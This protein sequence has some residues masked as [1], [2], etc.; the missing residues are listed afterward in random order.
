MMNTTQ[1][2]E[3]T[4]SGEIRGG[5]TN[6]TSPNNYMD[7]IA[8]ASQ[9]VTVVA[10]SGFNFGGVPFGSS[11]PDITPINELPSFNGGYEITDAPADATLSANISGDTDHFFVRDIYV[12]EWTWR[13]VDPGDLPPGFHGPRPKERVL[14]VVGFSDGTAPVAVKQHQYVL[15]RVF[16]EAGFV[17]GTFNA[18]IT[19]QGDTWETITVPLSL[20]IA[21]VNVNPSSILNIPQGG[22]AALPF[23]IQ[24]IAGPAVDGHF[25]MSP[26]QLD[27]GLT[28]A[29][30]NFILQP[31]ETQTVLLE[32][33]ADRNAPLGSEQVALDQYAFRRKGFF[34]TANILHAPIIVNPLIPNKIFVQ[35]R[36]TSVS[37]PIAIQNN[38]AATD[39]GFQPSFL[40]GDVTFQATSFYVEADMSVNLN[41]FIG[42][43]V[44]DEFNFSIEW[45]AWDQTGTMNFSV[46]ITEPETISLH[47][48]VVTDDGIPISG[49]VEM[50]LQSNGNYTFHGSMRATGG[51]S[52][53]YGLQVFVKAADGIIL[54]AFHSGNIY[55]TDTPGDRDDPWEENLNSALVKSEW[56]SIRNN[57]VIQ[58]QFNADIGGVIGTVWD[59]VKDGLEVVVGFMVGGVVGAGIVLGSEL[60]SAAGIPAPP[61]LVAGVAV[62]GG[63]VVLFGPGVIIPATVAGA[64]V[65]TAIELLI[66]TRPIRD[67]EKDFARLVFGNTL[68]EMFN[69]NKVWITNLSHDNG[70]KFTIPNLDG[71]VLLNL[72]DAYDDPIHYPNDDPKHVAG[73]GSDYTQPGAVFA[74]EL[75]HA[76]QIA[77]NKFVPGMICNAPGTYDYHSGDGEAH[78]LDDI[79]WSRLAWENDFT[80]EQQAHIVDDWYGA[81]CGN[82]TNLQEL[83]DN[84][85]SQTALSDPAFLFITKCRAGIF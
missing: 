11:G 82:F 42:D 85:T 56:V 66:K 50:I 68:D 83:N 28:L 18:T 63:A 73:A 6:D 9:A 21:D 51:P 38:G 69:E 25:E 48:D 60:A 67:D 41:V 45:L 49:W 22:K 59:I 24:S 39:V 61:G 57:P 26:T 13:F 35:R 84:L 33:T 53:D 27:T 70:R 55:G 76:C 1:Q 4:S 72:D 12:M 23:A 29:P 75:T 52:Y 81:Y 64:V 74:H 80:R 37:I 10:Q 71:S 43:A 78:R 7:T 14:E 3:M 32:F 31:G 2:P 20:F 58:Y 54:T 47:T 34:F 36:G 8:P 46:V 19:I 77:T 40:P 16:Y 62:V 79:G 15:V 44:M 30:N 5:Q 17:A 65:G